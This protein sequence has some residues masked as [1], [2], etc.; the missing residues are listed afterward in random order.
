MDVRGLG[1]L[2]STGLE[3]IFWGLFFFLKK[4]IGYNLLKII[5]GQNCIQFF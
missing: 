2:D 3:L 1:G 4:G 5:S